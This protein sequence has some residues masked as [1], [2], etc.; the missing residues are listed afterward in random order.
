[1]F[2]MLFAFV[3]TSALWAV[4]L[5]L[6][7]RWLGRNPDAAKALVDLLA[8]TFGKEAAGEK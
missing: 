2:L 7:L 4:G 1:M 5:V 3:L 8:R 6:G